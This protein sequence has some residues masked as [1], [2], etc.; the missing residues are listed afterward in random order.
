MFSKHALLLCA[1]AGAVGLAPAVRADIIT[2]WNFNSVPPNGQPNDGTFTPNI[3]VGTR[4]LFGGLTE[5]PFSAG[6]PADPANA[7]GDNSAWR[8]Q[9]N[10]PQG[11][12]SGG[13]GV[14]FGVSTVGYSGITVTWDQRYSS[15]SSRYMQLFYSVTGEVPFTALPV[16]F[17]PPSGATGDNWVTGQT[18]DLSSVPGVANNPN[19]RFRIAAVF[20]PDTNLYEAASALPQDVYGVGG[21]TQRYDMVT[22]SGTVTSSV[23]PVVSAPLAAPAYVCTTGGTVVLSA[24]VSPGQLPLSTG[25][26][27]EAN[28]SPLNGPSVVAMHDDGLG[29]DAAAGDNVYSATVTIGTVSAGSQTITLTARDLQGRTGTSTVQVSVADC[30][31]NSTSRVVIS[32]VYGG[33]SNLGPP[34]SPFNSDYVELYNRS[35]QTVDLTGWSV[36]YAGPIAA[37]G[38][39]SV[40]DQVLLCG[41]IKPGQ[42]ILVRMKN[43]G[44]TGAAIP[45]ADFSVAPNAG[46]MGNTGGRV[47]LARSTALIGTNCAH[48][49]VEDMVG[50]G[51]ASICF[52]G[53]AP[54]D[55]TANDTAAIRKAGGTQDSDQNFNDFTVGAPSPHNK[56]SGGFIAGYASVSAPFACRGTSVLLTVSAVGATAPASTGL[57]V[58]ADLSS[59][60]GSSNAS[61]YDDG[62]HGDQTPGDRV[63]SLDYSIPGSVVPGF[64]T[65]AVRTADAQ[66]RA[67]VTCVGLAVSACTVSSA[68]VVISQFFGGGG[69]TGAPLNADFVEIFNRSSSPVNLAGWSLQ[70]ADS[71][72]AFPPNKS[73][74]LSASAVAPGLLTINPGQYRLIQVNSPGSGGGALPAPDFIPPNPFGMDNQWGRLAL[75]SSTTS[76]GSNCSAASIVDLVGYGVYSACFEGLG[77]AT[78][79]DSTLVGLRKQGGCQDTNETAMDFDVVAPIDLPR[80]SATPA[81][82]CAPLPSGVCCRGATCTAAYTSAAACS[83]ALD[84]VSGTVQTRFVSS[85]SSCNTPVTIPGTLGNTI[86]PCCYAN[87]NHNASLEVQ[88]IFDFLNDWFAGKKAAI[89]G[90]DGSTG[91]LQVQNIF[92]F[93]NAWFA[94]G[95]N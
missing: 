13:R 41:D 79:L 57:N 12:E 15:T 74:D 47:A 5:T 33:G 82:L 50:Y 88:D 85:T 84:S 78:T 20:A 89:V 92:D 40:Y 28:L 23:G 21:N 45:A 58:T 2:Q 27:V 49:S 19:F 59:I 46:G 69:N 83:A 16:Y 72:G 60:G 80:N 55:T 14:E 36:Q 8:V 62:T 4:A 44:N 93:L 56:T 87:Y 77:P 18:A 17:S 52:E 91:T 64:K 25:L 31:I 39:N 6:S 81:N 76:I 51:S 54:T 94:G 7:A 35:A 48:P 30:S 38:F 24:T 63:F 34:A 9:T 11:A 65:I 43:A 1:L 67:D 53:V 95:C 42:Y 66:S 37:D 75:V 68:P 73:I 10:A 70:Y 26:T 86:A 71:T 22:V 32:Q 90:G 61:L 29:G 3:G